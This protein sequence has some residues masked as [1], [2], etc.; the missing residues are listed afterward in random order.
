MVLQRALRVA[1]LLTVIADQERRPWSG[2]D[3]MAAMTKGLPHAQAA[4]RVYVG[5]VLVRA[6][7]CCK[8]P[9]SRRM[10]RCW[11]THNAMPHIWA[12]I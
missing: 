3:A 10:Q 2:Q 8:V 11:C 9:P 1:L 5:A 12:P 7:P 4:L 6:G